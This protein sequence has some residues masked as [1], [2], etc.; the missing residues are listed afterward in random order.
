METTI[1]QWGY[2]GRME[3]EMEGALGA[4]KILSRRPFLAPLAAH[5]IH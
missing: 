2:M 5:S 1:V 4:V 3:N